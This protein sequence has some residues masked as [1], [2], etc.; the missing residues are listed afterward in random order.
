MS[1]MRTQKSFKMCNYIDWFT[2]DKLKHQRM[3][4]WDMVIR[5]DVNDL[6]DVLTLESRICQKKERVINM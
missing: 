2:E 4:I 1:I 5:E 3:W 6:E